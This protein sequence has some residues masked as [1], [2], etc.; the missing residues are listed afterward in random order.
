VENLDPQAPLTE[1]AQIPA[2]TGTR[3]NEGGGMSTRMGNRK[4]ER[5]KTGVLRGTVTQA[6]RAT[7]M[8]KETYFEKTPREGGK[9]IRKNRAGACQHI[10][11]ASK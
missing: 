1:V 2:K 4:G 10:L 8:G 6:R 7:A 11:I 9:T 3:S 5:R